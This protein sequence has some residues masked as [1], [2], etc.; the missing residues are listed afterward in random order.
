M[1]FELVVYWGVHELRRGCD[2]VLVEFVNGFA[3]VLNE[4]VEWV[5]GWG[6][7]ELWLGFECVADDCW[8]RFCE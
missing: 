6:L 7:N 1:R 5:C 3:C 8:M 4:C 2:C